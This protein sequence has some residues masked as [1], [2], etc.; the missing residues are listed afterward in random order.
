MGRVSL[1]DKFIRSGDDF[2][3]FVNSSSTLA[4]CRETHPKNELPNEELGVA[5]LD[6]RPLTFILIQK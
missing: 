4:N 2:V 5:L 6:V 3:K 1:D